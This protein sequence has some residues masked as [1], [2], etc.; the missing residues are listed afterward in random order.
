M[1]EL[2]IHCQ[3]KNFIF[4]TNNCGLVCSK[5]AAKAVAPNGTL[6]RT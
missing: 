6:M 2:N 5:N 3:M 4:H 1:S